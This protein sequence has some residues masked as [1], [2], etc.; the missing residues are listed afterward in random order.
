M[1][2]QDQLHLAV[3]SRRLRFLEWPGVDGNVS[4]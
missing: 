1:G 2:F 3:R 4:Y